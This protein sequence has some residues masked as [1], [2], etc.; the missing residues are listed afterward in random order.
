MKA[1][2]EPAKLA[3]E[4]MCRQ[5]ATL[6]TAERIFLF[7]IRKMKN[8]RTALA[9]KLLCHQKPNTAKKKK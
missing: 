4:A 3:V 1:A 7:L 5:N 8:Q 6:L 9:Q 2:L